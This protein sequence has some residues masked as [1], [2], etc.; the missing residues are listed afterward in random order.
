M[1]Q[2]FVDRMADGNPSQVRQAIEGIEWASI[3]IWESI[4]FSE[5]GAPDWPEPDF[6]K[7]LPLAKE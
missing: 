2:V 7:A 6:I 4:L 3:E 1:D 5:T